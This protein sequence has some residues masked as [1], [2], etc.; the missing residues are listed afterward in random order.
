V[1]HIAGEIRVI[2]D[3]PTAEGTADGQ[4]IDK[5]RET[6]DDGFSPVYAKPKRVLTVSPA[7]IGSFLYG[8]MLDNIDIIM[9]EYEGVPDFALPTENTPNPP[10]NPPGDEETGN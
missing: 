1:R 2:F 8:V 5:A 3:G 9:E 4:I 6:L 10:A 7:R